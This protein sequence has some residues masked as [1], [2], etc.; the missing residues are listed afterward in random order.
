MEP[1]VWAS[2]GRSIELP[3]EEA[4]FVFCVVSLFR[5]SLYSSS[6][7]R[8]VEAGALPSGKFCCLPFIGST[9]PSDFLLPRLPFS[10]HFIEAALRQV[11]SPRLMH[12]PFPHSD[13]SYAGG[14][15]SSN[16]IFRMRLSPSP[17]DTWLSLLFS[18]STDTSRGGRIHFM[19]R[20]AELFPFFFKGLCSRFAQS[21]SALP[22]RLTS[23][24]LGGYPVRTWLISS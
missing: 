17:Y 22:R 3:L 2:L 6:F 20:T 13:P 21:L 24:P 23:G 18:L 1:P 7:S 4:Y 12:Q 14:F 16:P 15:A 8:L 19:L 11:G 5:H 10:V 9:T